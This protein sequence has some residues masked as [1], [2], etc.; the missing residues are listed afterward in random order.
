MYNII[1]NPSVKSFQS[2][3]SL[4]SHFGPRNTSYEGYRENY[5]VWEE[6]DEEAAAAAEGLLYQNI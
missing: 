1:I 6:G 5:F 4:G 3:S 2:G